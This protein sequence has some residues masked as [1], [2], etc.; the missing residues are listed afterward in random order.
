MAGAPAD[1][2]RGERGMEKKEREHTRGG[3]EGQQSHWP[4]SGIL[5]FPH[6]PYPGSEGRLPP[7][8]G[9]GE[10]VSAPRGQAQFAHG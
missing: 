5:G 9:P 7:G 2:P 10:G 6:G 8:L 4:L 3:R 1:A